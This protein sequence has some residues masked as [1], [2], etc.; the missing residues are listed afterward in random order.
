MR[1]PS[2]HITEKKL[3][4]VLDRILG[5]IQLYKVNTKELAKRILYESRGLSCNNRSIKITNDRL[6][7]KAKQIITSSKSDAFLLADLIYKFRKKQKHRGVRRI[8]ED[9]REWGQLKKLAAT[10][11]DFCNDFE[12]DKRK[13]FIIYLE[14]AFSKISS[15]RQYLSKFTNMYESIAQ[16]YEFTQEIQAD[17]NPTETREIHDL[18]VA[19]IAKRTGIPEKYDK[20]PNKYVYFKRVREL[21]DKIDIPHDVFI[22]AQ[23]EGL[24]WADS[25]PGPAQL[26]GDKAIERLN[27]Y[28]FNRNMK[29]GSKGKAKKENT[30]SDVLKKIKDGNN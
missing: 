12:M 29:R 18:Y 6:E 22:E 20:V 23:F 28:M 10:C 3:V 24:A 19:T 30:L 7:K 25:F 27:K 9:D 4:L 11:V 26:I 16:E 2:L 1:E 21:T 8:S 17:D 15:T 5:D 13:G 14:I